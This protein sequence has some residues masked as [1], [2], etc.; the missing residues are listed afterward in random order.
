MV[1]HIGR[2][3]GTKRQTPIMAFPQ[4]GG[5]IVAL[6]YGSNADWVKNV[7]TAN[8][9]ALTYKKKHYRLDSPEI[10]SADPS[11][12]PLPS[13]V[14]VILKANRVHEFLRLSTEAAA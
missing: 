11:T 2:K 7:T 5:F 4:A 14:K 6:T 8:R 1:E 10:F 3:S 12:L 9:C 13:Y